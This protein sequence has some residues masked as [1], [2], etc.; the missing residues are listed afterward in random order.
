VI[1]NV[2]FNHYNHSKFQPGSGGYEY[3][4]AI[5][6]TDSGTHSGNILITENGILYVGRLKSNAH[7]L[8]EHEQKQIARSG[9][10]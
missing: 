8:V 2:K 6:D 5:A 10:K 1:N 4:I 9:K 3:V 7:M